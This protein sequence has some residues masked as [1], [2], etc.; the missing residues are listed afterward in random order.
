MTDSANENA[1]VT[2]CVDGSKLSDS[3]CDYAAWIARTVDAPLKLLHTIDHHQEH[4]EAADLSGN[5]VINNRDQLLASLTE[6]EQVR[7]KSRIQAG[8]SLLAAARDRLDSPAAQTE[9]CLQ[10][11]ALIDSLIELEDRIRVLV[12]G[13]RGKV[14][15]DQT[16]QIGDK[17]ES[18]IRS[19]HR[20][21][22]VA[23]EPFKKPVTIMLASNGTPAAE[24]AVE[25]VANSALFKG[26]TCHLVHV[27]KKADVDSQ[28][29]ETAGQRLE[30]AG[31][32]VITRQLEGRAE[33][34]LVLYQQAEKIDLTIMGAYSHTRLHDLILGSFTTRMLLHTHTPLLLLR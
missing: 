4:A 27:V 34:E 14:H 32:N 1:F 29:L 15:E 19:L 3:V 23:Y 31:L 2:A 18:M 20:P 12:I 25:M 28:H 5:L 22:L 21:I 8:K 9:L 13:A 10:H 17:L 33:Q 11:G 6:E 24:K 16:D 26:I 7:F 30:K